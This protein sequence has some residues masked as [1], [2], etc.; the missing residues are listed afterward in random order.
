MEPIGD[1][2]AAALLQQLADMGVTPDQAA[3]EIR[4]CGPGQDLRKRGGPVT[5][6]FR[7]RREA[8]LPRLA[9]NPGGRKL[10]PRGRAKNFAW[11]VSELSRLVNEHV[12]GAAADRQISRLI[13]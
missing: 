3:E 7:T 5:I 2:H 13:S 10:D 4:R 1:Q 12:G 11:V 9:I 6:A 8:S